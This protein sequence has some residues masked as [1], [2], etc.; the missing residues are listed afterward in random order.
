[1]ETKIENSNAAPKAKVLSDTKLAS[2]K[3]NKK[4]TWQALQNIIQRLDSER[5][6]DNVTVY[7]KT[8]NEYFA[9]DSVCL[10]DKNNDVLD[11]G[12]LVLTINESGQEKKD[13]S[14]TTKKAI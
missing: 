6:Q 10:S 4:L 7:L 11:A 14:E 3:A 5:R 1:M 8:Q 2:L 13:G 9:V 12:H